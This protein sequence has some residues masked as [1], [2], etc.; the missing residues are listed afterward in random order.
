MLRGAQRQNIAARKLANTAVNG[1]G[2]QERRRSA[3]KQP[4]NRGRGSQAEIPEKS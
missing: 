3:C 4:E 2:E 1:V